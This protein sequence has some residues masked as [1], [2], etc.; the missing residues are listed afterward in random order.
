MNWRVGWVKTAEDELADIWLRAPDR[1]AIT[2]AASVIDQ[3]LERD[4]Y[5]KS[6]SR[7]DGERIAFEK[8]LAVRYRV[9][10]EQWL[11]TVLRVWHFD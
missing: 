8:P 4:P 7:E 10:P 6:E 5:D 1:D 11:V 3:R 9:I 2:A